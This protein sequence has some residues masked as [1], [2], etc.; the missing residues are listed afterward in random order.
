MQE[1]TPE[2]KAQLA[3]VREQLI[4]RAMEKH[5]WT[6]A[7]DDRQRKE[8]QL[9]R[10]YAQ[11]LAHGTDGHHRLLLIAK[12]AEMLDACHNVHATEKPA[13]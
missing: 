7:L 9:A 10:Y 1:L 13:K 5:D 3:E 11:N 6:L 12:L 2:L 4:Q 8:L